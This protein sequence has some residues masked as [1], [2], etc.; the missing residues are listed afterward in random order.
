MSKF[1]S[2]FDIITPKQFGFTKGL[3]TEHAIIEFTESAY[4]ALNNEEYLISAFIDFRR[5]FDT[6]NHEILLRKLDAYGIRGTANNF[7]NSYLTNR[8]VMS[9]L[10][11]KNP[12]ILF[13]TL[14]CLK[15]LV[16]L[17]FYF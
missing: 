15:G 8:R 6:L 3:T 4:S 10:V 7:I 12:W 5:A 2:D 17:Q 13:N 11:I 1:L 14:V 16:F 9:K